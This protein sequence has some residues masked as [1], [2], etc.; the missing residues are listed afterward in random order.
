M[1]FKKT[2]KTL[3]VVVVI[4][5]RSSRMAWRLETGKGEI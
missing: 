4:V 1:A 3:V 5:V 2:L